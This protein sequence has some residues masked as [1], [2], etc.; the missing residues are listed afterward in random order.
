MF[1]N[2]YKSF[3]CEED[4]YLLELVRYIH[5]NPVRAGM[6]S[7]LKAL[8]KYEMSGH[9]AIM[10]RVMNDWQDTDYVLAYFGKKQ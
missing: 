9:A 2:R 10:G 4:P 3:L 8:S 5:L 7:D 1:Q 6:V